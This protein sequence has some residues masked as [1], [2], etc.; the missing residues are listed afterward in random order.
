MQQISFEALVKK[1]MK[2]K[3]VGI[4]WHFHMIG[5]ACIFSRSKEQ[6]EIK[7][8]SNGEVF[9]SHFSEK[10]ISETRQMAEVAYGLDFLK[11]EKNVDKEIRSDEKVAKNEAFQKIMDR[12]RGCQA[13]GSAW[14]NHHL[15]PQCS[16]NPNK[17]EHCIVFEDETG[18]DA[19]Y[20][21]YDHDP[22]D[23]LAELERL[24]F[25]KGG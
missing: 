21:Y 9:S 5:P 16:L 11:R 20:A 6:Y 22:V 10:P 1:A 7:I 3:Q 18:G 19:L 8:E 17:G 13:S 14:H 24:F 15:P 23:D 2:L 25:V 12:A 4:K